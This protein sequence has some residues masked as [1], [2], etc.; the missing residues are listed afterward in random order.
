M[1]AEN[2]DLG[3]W[4]YT[5]AYQH[6]NLDAGLDQATHPVLVV[7]GD[8]DQIAPTEDSIR[9]ADVLE[10]A[11][12]VVFPSCGHVPQEERPEALLCAV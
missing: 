6:L 5:L 4:E 3:L 12:L 11:S 1:K 9:F 2:G 7:T 10:S 8:D